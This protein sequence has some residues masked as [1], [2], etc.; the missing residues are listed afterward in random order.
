[1]NSNFVSKLV[2]VI[3]VFTLVSVK[4][5]EPLSLE[6]QF[7]KSPFVI[8]GQTVTIAPDIVEQTQQERLQR[9]LLIARN[10]YQFI[11]G[12]TIPDN[13]KVLVIEESDLDIVVIDNNLPADTFGGDDSYRVIMD[14]SGKL[15]SIGV[16]D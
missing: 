15:E 1:M 6:M 9:Q 4:G 5:A 12:A 8:S 13:T 3:G 16:S 7:Q 11:E 10:G 14:K 2:L